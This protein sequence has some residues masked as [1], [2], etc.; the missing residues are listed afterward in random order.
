MKKEN[1][2]SNFF[3]SYPR[4]C[5]VCASESGSM[6]GWTHEAGLGCSCI[7]TRSTSKH[8]PVTVCI[9]HMGLSFDS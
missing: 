1:N 6:R 3:I 7:E 4:R 5:F 9:I 2:K 8:I